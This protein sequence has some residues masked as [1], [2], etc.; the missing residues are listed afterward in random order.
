MDRAQLTSTASS[1]G[2][3]ARRC[4][5][6]VQA[7]ASSCVLPE[8]PEVE[9]TARTVALSMNNNSGLIVCLDVLEAQA[10]Q[11]CSEVDPNELSTQT[12]TSSTSLLYENC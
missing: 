11:T 5:F 1:Q 7:C 8:Y 2:S 6:V 3:S 4:V 12:I 9:S 10:F